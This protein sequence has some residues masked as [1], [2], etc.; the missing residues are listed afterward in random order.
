[1][2]QAGEYLRRTPDDFHVLMGRDTM[3]FA[4]L[5]QGAAGAIAASAN[6]A[7]ELSVGI[8]ENFAYGDLAKSLDFQRRLNPLR[9][10]FGLG[11][12]PAVLKTGLE[13]LGIA[14]GPPRAPIGRLTATERE[15]LRDILIQTGKI[16]GD[17]REPVI[18]VNEPE[19]EEAVA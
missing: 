15:Q 18:N 4:G 9:L 3:I 19:L 6:L 12:F 1:M 2:T 16:K 13:L 10:A 8:F 17:A 14:V 5:V 7:P 11:S